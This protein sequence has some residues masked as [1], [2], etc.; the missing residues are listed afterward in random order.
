MVNQISVS[1]R[2]L[3]LCLVA[4]LYNIT[5]HASTFNVGS[6][7][8]K[9]ATQIKLQ[10]SLKSTTNKDTWKLPKVEATLP[11][12]TYWDI[13][14]EAIYTVIDSEHK[15][16]QS[17]INDSVLK[18]TLTFY[19]TS[20]LAL[21]LKPKFY[22]PTGDADKGLGKG[23]SAFKLP[24]VAN[25][26]FDNIWQAGASAEYQRS[27]KTESFS[28]AALLTRQLIPGVILG[29]ELLTNSKDL[30]LQALTHAYDAGI[31]WKPGNGWK[32]SAVGTHVFDA[33][34]GKHGNTYEFKVS[35]VFK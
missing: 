29:A 19:K 21:A 15:P 34:D 7:N 23:H 33:P 26:A 11:I 31:E 24:I 30:H 2:I 8:S 10:G 4:S 9:Q 3:V 12:T 5:A 28:A 32:L 13:S 18:S 35:K 16:T 1:I 6:A 25:Y 20:N 22:F 27:F 14:A 17:G